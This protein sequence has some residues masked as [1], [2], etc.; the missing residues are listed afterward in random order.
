MARTTKTRESARARAEDK[1][2]ALIRRD[3]QIKD[4]I[5][6][7]RTA[8]ADKTAK[9]RALRLQKEAEDARRAKKAKAKKDAAAPKKTA[10][11]RKK[12]TDGTAAEP[13]SP[14]RPAAR[15]PRKVRRIT[16]T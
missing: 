16:F 6:Q 3:E 7:E 11:S 12:T 2:A 4:E 8:L 10:S 1:Y 13:A 5:Q 9:L 15:K 14:P